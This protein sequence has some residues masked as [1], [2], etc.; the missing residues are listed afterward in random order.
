MKIAESLQENKKNWLKILIRRKKIVAPGNATIFFMIIIN[1]AF[2]HPIF[3][4]AGKHTNFFMSKRAGSQPF[5]R[6]AATNHF[7]V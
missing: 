6:R 4:A 3:Q 7:G 1:L 5:L 2:Y